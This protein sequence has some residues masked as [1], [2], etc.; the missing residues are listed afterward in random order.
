MSTSLV[1]VPASL[2]VWVPTLR[3]GLFKFGCTN[4]VSYSWST[5]RWMSAASLVCWENEEERKMSCVVM[6]AP[7]TMVVTTV[8]LGRGSKGARGRKSQYTS[9]CPGLNRQNRRR[10]VGVGSQTD[11]SHTS[12]VSSG[13][14]R[15][16]ALELT[17]FEM[18]R[19]GDEDSGDESTRTRRADGVVG[20][21]STGFSKRR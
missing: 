15:D 3:T 20:A 7:T 13:C 6:R 21:V 8:T 4:F 14:A 17:R 18:K 16:C 2:S 11:I 12:F 5:S 10:H 9:T 19:K 1:L